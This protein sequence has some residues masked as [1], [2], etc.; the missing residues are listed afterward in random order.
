MDFIGVIG[1]FTEWGIL[2]LNL[3][4]VTVLDGGETGACSLGNLYMVWLTV[5]MSPCILLVN[6]SVVKLEEHDLL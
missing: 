4:L 5:Q 6:D 2:T 1:Y 3:V